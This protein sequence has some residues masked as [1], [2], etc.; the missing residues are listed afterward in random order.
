MTLVAA[1]V[2]AYAAGRT[3]NVHPLTKVDLQDLDRDPI[4]S[5]RG[6][7][8]TFTNRTSRKGRELL[9]NPRAALIFHWP[10]PGRRVRVEG[11]VEETK[12][13]LSAAYWESR[14]GGSRIAAENRL[15][16]RVRFALSAEGWTRD[17][18]AP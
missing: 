12:L 17:R 14:P 16:D 10:E 11:Q 4:V 1:M 2:G 6:A 18:L 7:E 5:L 8:D 3:A 15:H 9:E 13:E